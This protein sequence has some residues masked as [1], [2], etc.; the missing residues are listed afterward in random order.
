MNVFFSNDFGF[1][2][3]SVND[4]L[5]DEWRKKR[6]RALVLQFFFVKRL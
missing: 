6:L 4:L 2:P 1:K 5:L 3:Q